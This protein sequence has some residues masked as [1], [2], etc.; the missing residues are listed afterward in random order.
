MAGVCTMQI[1]LQLCV[2]LVKKRNRNCIKILGRLLQNCDDVF[3]TIAF[4]EFLEMHISALRTN[5][6]LIEI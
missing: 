5:G 1:T 3:H 2:P 4:K 6:A